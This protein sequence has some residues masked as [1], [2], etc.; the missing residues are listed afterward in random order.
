[1]PNP[2]LPTQAPTVVD[3]TRYLLERDSG[4]PSA[5][6]IPTAL[7]QTPIGSGGRED[8]LNWTY[9]QPTP[10]GAVADG[11][12]VFW[13][14][15]ATAD[16]QTNAVLVSAQQ[17]SWSQ[18]VPGA[19]PVSYAIAAYRHTYQGE[20]LGTKVQHATWSGAVAVTGSIEA[21]VPLTGVRDGVNRLF[22]APWAIALASGRPLAAV[23]WRQAILFYDPA[24][25][26]E[27]GRWRLAASDTVELGIAPEPDDP[28]CLLYA[29][30]A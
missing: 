20:V 2:R 25:A 21:W 5:V 22:V 24:T 16:P 28:L 27:P 17:R 8:T 4:P 26:V 29:V 19:V 18:I 10:R 3:L 6:P 7:V 12:L 9:A 1:M 30:A 14:R 11:F 13:E 15:G 23:Y